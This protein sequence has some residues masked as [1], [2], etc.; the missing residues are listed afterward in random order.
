MG[1]LLSQYSIDCGCQVSAIEA[2]N[3]QVVRLALF[4]WLSRVSRHRQPD[5]ES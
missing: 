2:C 5:Q 1:I 3:I 4:H